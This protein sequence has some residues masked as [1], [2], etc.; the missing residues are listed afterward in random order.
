MFI[1]RVSDFKAIRPAPKELEL[2]KMAIWATVQLR[3]KGRKQ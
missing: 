3:E 1:N 2:C